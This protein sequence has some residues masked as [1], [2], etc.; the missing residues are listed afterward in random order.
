MKLHAKVSSSVKK[1]MIHTKVADKSCR[2]KF[3]RMYRALVSR[4]KFKL[5]DVLQIL[6]KFD[7]AFDS[8]VILVICNST[9]YQHTIGIVVP[10]SNIL[11]QID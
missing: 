4:Y 3:H 5:Q 11:G 8:K 9:C 10:N 1:C 7:L 2:Q 6:N